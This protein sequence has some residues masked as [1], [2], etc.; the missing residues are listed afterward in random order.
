MVEHEDR[1]SGRM[2][3]LGRIR[4]EWGLDDLFGGR[5]LVGVGGSF[6]CHG[7]IDICSSQRGRVGGAFV[8]VDL[9]E[10]RC[11]EC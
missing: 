8:W 11:G 2:M 1:G 10:Y 6:I 9:L 3:S 5:L 4:S 7:E